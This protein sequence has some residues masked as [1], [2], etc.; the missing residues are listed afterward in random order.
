MGRYRHMSNL[1]FTVSFAVT[2]SIV[3]W[4]DFWNLL[5]LKCPNYLRKHVVFPSYC[6]F[7]GVFQL[8]RNSHINISEKGQIWFILGKFLSQKS[9][10]FPTLIEN[11]WLTLKKLLQSDKLSTFPPE[12]Q[13]VRD[14]WQLALHVTGVAWRPQAEKSVSRKRL[15]LGWKTDINMARISQLNF[16][17]SQKTIF[18]IIIWISLRNQDLA[19]IQDIFWLLTLYIMFTP[20]PSSSYIETAGKQKLSLWS[21]L[22]YPHLQLISGAYHHPLHLLS[23]QWLSSPPS[24]FALFLQQN[25]CSQSFL[26]VKIFHLNFKMA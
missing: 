20:S 5:Y 14:I 23:A 9:T 4:S 24:C 6:I 26:G 19:I 2:W 16:K 22:S 1:K 12:N 3:I 17:V 25:I 15:S 7:I 13:H 18:I 10:S 21:A 8:S 11:E